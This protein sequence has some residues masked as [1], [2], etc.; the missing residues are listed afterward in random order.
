LLQINQRQIRSEV[1]GE[2]CPKLNRPEFDAW[3]YDTAQFYRKDLRQL[4][5]TIFDT[6][7][8]VFLTLRGHRI[9]ATQK[10]VS[11]TT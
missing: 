8:A 6:L 5:Q 3:I 4:N 9:F 1:K 2:S 11:K 10:G 7:T